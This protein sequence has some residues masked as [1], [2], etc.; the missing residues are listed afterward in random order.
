VGLADS[1]HPTAQFI[2]REIQSQLKRLNLTAAEPAS[3]ATFLR[4]ATI[5]ALGRLPTV[6]EIRAF[7][8]NHDPNKRDAAIDRLL[9]EPQHA[10]LWAT[11]LCDLTGCRLETMEGPEDRKPLRARMWHEWFRRRLL[12]RVPFDQIVRGVIG[13]TS[14][15]GASAEEY[16]DREAALIRAAEAGGTRDYWRRSSLD[17]FYRRPEVNGV[18]PREE[19]AERIAAAFLGIRIQCA[20]CHTHPHDRWTQGD[21][22]AFVNIF[23]DVTFGSSTELNEA[24]FARLAEQR[25]QRAEGKTIEPLP[26]IQEVYDDPQLGRRLL[27]P[28]SRTAPSP[29]PL[30]G[31]AFETSANARTALANWLTSP[32]NHQFARNWVNRIWRHYMGRGLVEPVDGFSATNPPSHP[33]LLERLATEFIVSRFDMRH[34]ERLILTSDVYHQ[35]STP[36]TASPDADRYYVSASV[37]PLM[38][39]TLVQAL[40][41]V[42]KTPADWDADVPAGG[43]L[44]DV[45]AN[46]PSDARLAYLLALF[47]RGDRTSVCD[48][49]RAIEPTL[50][51]TLHLMSDAVW[52]E[53]IQK[54][55][56]IDELLAEPDPKQ[57]VQ[58]AVRQALSRHPS[59]EEEELF[60]AHLKAA[61]DPRTA[62]IDVVWALVNSRQFRTNH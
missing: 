21:Y 57:A 26:R 60:V 54:S 8:D 23:A 7:L 47:G 43:T 46:R 10:S 6:E 50:R 30:G 25:R 62:W 59:P 29:R 20:R 11:R 53:Q 19:L 49:D 14:R 2:D 42:L 52:I 12:E 38:A 58:K 40:Q 22:A 35:S 17:L 13:G 34:I 28:E 16:L 51:Q 37:R 55:K 44:F 5:D 56:L 45:A 9:A 27:D 3:D 15:D 18:Y 41:Q 31:P 1:A 39:E 48:C 33:D 24:I 32:D 61:D 36:A 4:R